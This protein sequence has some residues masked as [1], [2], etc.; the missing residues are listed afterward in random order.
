MIF[1]LD[2]LLE[3]LTGDVT[4]LCNTAPA[5]VSKSFGPRLGIVTAKGEMKSSG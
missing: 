4:G 2:F 3:N 5:E 1:W